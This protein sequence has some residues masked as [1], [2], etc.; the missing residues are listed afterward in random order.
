[1]NMPAETG[2]F[3]SSRPASKVVLSALLAAVVFALLLWSGLLERAEMGLRDRIVGLLVTEQPSNLLILEIDSASIEAVG[4]WP[5]PRSVYASA[6]NSLGDAGIRSLMIDVDFSASSSLGGDSELEDAIQSISEA[7]PTF[8]PVFVQRRSQEDSALMIRHPLPAL[9]DNAELV[10]VT[11][12]RPMMAW[13]GFS[14]LVSGGRTV[15][16]VE[17]GVRW[18]RMPIQALGLITPFP[19]SLF[20]TLALLIFLRAGCQRTLCVVGT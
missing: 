3:V 17:P 9:A 7:V 2:S 15:F 18:R 5:W 6:I 13:C 1:M 20:A 8:L 19:R 4:Q 12:I 14:P 16:I 11:C 10:S